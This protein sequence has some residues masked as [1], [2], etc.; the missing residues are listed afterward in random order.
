MKRPLNRSGLSLVELLV[1]VMVLTVGILGMVAGTSWVLRMAELARLDTQRAI[2][3]Q[4]AIEE[5]KSMPLA[6]VG[7][8]SADSGNFT[9]TW[10][11]VSNDATSATVRFVLVGPGRN[12]SGGITSSISG[13]ATD[14]LVYTRVR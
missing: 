4:S 1:A 13:T 7:S 8:G 5:V 6:S 12:R 9:T 3:M 14:T 2:A 10:T 11:V